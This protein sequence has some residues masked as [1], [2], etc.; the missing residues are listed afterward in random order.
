VNIDH[1]L[2]QLQ[3]VRKTATGEWVACCPAHEDRSPSLSLKDCGDGRLLLHCFGGCAVEEVCLALGLTL[4][5][6]MP[7]RTPDKTFRRMPFNAATVL[8]V[9]AVKAGAAAI[10]SN[11]LAAGKQLSG[12]DKQ[13]LFDSAAFIHEALTYV[14]ADR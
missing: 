7:E 4:S 3:K 9:I 1:L 13:A 5:D 11:D 8:A 10:A 12:G 14:R 6:L 2:S